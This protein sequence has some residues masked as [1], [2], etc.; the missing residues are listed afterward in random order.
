MY[1]MYLHS[2]SCVHPTA[3]AIWRIVTKGIGCTEH[4]GVCAT[5]E[6]VYISITPNH[7]GKQLR[8]REGINCICLNFRSYHF[9]R[10]G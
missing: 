10:L 7:L 8:Q 3:I 9:S 2:G 4:A 1:N 6:A 5:Q